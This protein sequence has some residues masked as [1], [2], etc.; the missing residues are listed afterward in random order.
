MY[1]GSALCFATIHGKC[2]MQAESWQLMK[3]WPAIFTPHAAL[4][5]KNMPYLKR[6]ENTSALPQ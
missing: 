1:V 2:A 4:Y 5:S 3:A 6:L